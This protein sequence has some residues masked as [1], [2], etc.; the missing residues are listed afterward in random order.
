MKN[1]PIKTNLPE[2]YIEEQ[3]EDILF[4]VF[5]QPKT[6]RQELLH[7]ELVEFRKMVKK[8]LKDEITDYQFTLH[9]NRLRIADDFNI[10]QV[11]FYKL[12]ENKADKINADEVEKQHHFIQ[13]I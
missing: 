4:M 8:K 11:N 7:I 9:V 12:D 2:K 6:Q 1:D 13:R 3:I 5:N 10:G